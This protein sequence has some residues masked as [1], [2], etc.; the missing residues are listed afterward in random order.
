LVVDVPTRVVDI[1]GTTTSSDTAFMK[2]MARTLTDMADG[3]LNAKR[4]LI[5][6]RDTKFSPM[7][8][9]LTDAGIRVLR[10]PYRAPNA[11]AYAER[12]VRSIKSECLDRMIFFGVNSLHRSLA[13][14]VQH[15]HRERNH[16]GLENEIIQSGSEVGVT[17]GRILR[18]QRLGGMLNYY[19]R[20]A[21]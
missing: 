21:A 11:N 7:L 16:Q 5:L 14:Y 19:Y 17:H 3:F 13:Q 9:T 18:R 12:F 8:G 20:P 6:D 10:C 15:Y 1:A 4:R 2:Q